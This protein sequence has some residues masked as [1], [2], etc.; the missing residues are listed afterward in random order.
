MILGHCRFTLEELVYT[1]FFLRS[2]YELECIHS[3]G[4]PYILSMR[5]M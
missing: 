4:S 5:A 1:Y 3:Y 2:E